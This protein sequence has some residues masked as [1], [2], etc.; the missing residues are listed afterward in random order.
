MERVLDEFKLFKDS[1][2]SSTEQNLGINEVQQL[3]F[4]VEQYER[5][6]PIYVSKLKDFED[7]NKRLVD[8]KQALC[9]DIEQM[10]ER[11]SN[12]EAVVFS[13]GTPEAIRQRAPAIEQAPRPEVQTIPITSRLPDQGTRPKDVPDSPMS[14]PEMVDLSDSPP[15][16]ASNQSTE[17][18]SKQPEP[19]SKKPVWG[20][21]PSSGTTKSAGILSILKAGQKPI[22]QQN[23][24][25]GGITAGADTDMGAG[26]G[27]S[28][29][30]PSPTPKLISLTAGSR[31]EDANGKR[32]RATGPTLQ[33]Q[34][35]PASK[36]PLSQQGDSPREDRSRLPA[37]L[38]R[39]RQERQEL[40]KEIENEVK[41]SCSAIA[42][43][44]VTRFEDID[45]WFYDLRDAGT[46]PPGLLVQESRKMVLTWKAALGNRYHPLQHGAGSTI[47]PLEHAYKSFKA[48]TSGMS[49]SVW[50]SRAIARVQWLHD[51]LSIPKLVAKNG[52]PLTTRPVPLIF[53][54]EQ[55]LEDMQHIVAH[56]FET[57]PRTIFY[58]ISRGT[59]RATSPRKSR[60]APSERSSSSSSTRFDQG[61][62]GWQTQ[63]TTRSKKSAR[64]ADDHFQ[65]VAK[66]I[67]E[68]NK[69][70][71]NPYE[72]EDTE[73]Y[74]WAFDSLLSN[75][76]KD[77]IRRSKRLIALIKENDPPKNYIERRKSK[78]EGPRNTSNLTIKEYDSDAIFELEQFVEDIRDNNADK[79]IVGYYEDRIG[80]RKNIT[81]NDG[82]S[83]QG[84]F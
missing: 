6:F 67:H 33:D 28:T 56:Q 65:E 27:A 61:H 32:L 17:P 13:F 11:L 26:D 54:Y 38:P 71:P 43:T 3:R 4:Q 15:G 77:L 58:P 22:E 69:S 44:K 66:D 62:S 81:F 12:A 75:E 20:A 47:M 84:P 80:S 78:V 18:V 16:P 9:K 59:N 8:E 51:I 63:R 1:V 48:V 82:P 60:S 10:K 25:G 53:Y 70:I 55:L 21:E 52:D 57:I 76:K 64:T 19:V 79:Q 7:Q 50:V 39:D 29:S 41:R 45:H 49:I 83:G 2:I 31:A 30:V 24:L 42:W 68:H 72:H 37:S 34:E 46:E 23:T 14:T 74:N 40:E 73:Q 36:R 5:V 35:Q